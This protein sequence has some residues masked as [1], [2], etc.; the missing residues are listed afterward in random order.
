M[1]EALAAVCAISVG[2]QT[3][4]SHCQLRTEAGA[5]NLTT[6]GFVTPSDTTA[7]SGVYDPAK[8]HVRV[9]AAKTTGMAKAVPAVGR[10]ELDDEAQRLTCFVRL[11]GVDFTLRAA[12][13]L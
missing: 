3:E 2:A 13:I 10:C 7:I 4:H 1:L 5:D 8:D 9:L 12:F 11:N 6:F